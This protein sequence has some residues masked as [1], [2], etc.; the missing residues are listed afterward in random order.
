MF[1]VVGG[2][3]RL[4]VTRGAAVVDVQHDVAVIGE[5]LRGVL[6]ADARLTAR[7]AVDHDDGGDFRVGLGLM[8]F[9]EHAGDDHAVER[10]EA[11]DLRVDEVFR[12]D[13]LAQRIGQPR[14]LAALEIVDVEVRRRAVRIDIHGHQVLAR[15]EQHEVDVGV[16]QF[17][18]R[19][20]F[21]ALRV[22]QLHDRA[23]VFVDARDAI[24]ALLG[25]RAAEDVPLRR[26]DVGRLARG[27]IIAAQAGELGSVVRGEEEVLRL[28]IEVGRRELRAFLVFRDLLHLVLGDGVDEEIVVRGADRLGQGHP[29]A[30]RRDPVDLVT[31]LVLENHRPL[32][33]VGVV[34]VEIEVLRI[35]LVRDDE[36]RLLVAA[37]PPEHRLQLLARREVMLAAVLLPDVQMIELVASLIARVEKTRVLR[38]VTDRGGRVGRR[39][40]QRPRLPARHRDRVNVADAAFIGRKENLLFIRRKRRA[41]D[42]DG[43]DELF[44]RVLLRRPRLRE[45]RGRQDQG[46]KE[47]ADCALH[48]AS[49]RRAGAGVAP[50]GQ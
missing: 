23:R 46:E 49:I 35:A 42:G 17:R 31:G 50:E 4:P 32:V 48:G 47:K 16:R 7:A 1:A 12:I 24:A 43:G 22:V 3:E 10:L 5:V 25:K 8:R 26:L 40:R 9:V 28:R 6:V 21:A 14:G 37:P 11:D 38:K 45:Q 19:D 34:A 18:Q 36:E 13:L 39:R 33:R 20:L 41:A 15:R 27:Q 29:L 30:V 2:E 44:D